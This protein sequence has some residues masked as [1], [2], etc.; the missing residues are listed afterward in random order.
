[1]KVQTFEAEINGTKYERLTEAVGAAQGGDTIRLINTNEAGDIDK[2]IAADIRITKKLTID[3]N[4]RDITSAGADW[5]FTL[6]GEDGKL[7]L[8]NSGDKSATLHGGICN[9]GTEEFLHIGEKIHL[10]DWIYHN[11]NTI[12]D[13]TH[14]KLYLYSD[15]NLNGGK[16]MPVTFGDRFQ[17]TGEEASL[18]MKLAEPAENLNAPNIEV[19]EIVIAHKAKADLA[20][21]VSLLGV[22]NPLVKVVFKPASDSAK[23]GD[24]VVQKELFSAVYLNG[25]SGDDAKDG[26]TQ[27]TAV[28]TFGK[29]KELAEALA[30]NHDRVVVYVTGTV[31]V[32][33]A[34]TWEFSS[35]GKIT[36][37]RE[38]AFSGNL[39]KV[40]SSGNLTLKNIVIDGN[41][42]NADAGKNSLI[43]VDGGKLTM[44]SGAVLQNNKLT[45]LEACPPSAGGA[46]YARENATVTLKGGTI[47]GN[48]A[49]W[50]GGIFALNAVI[51]VE[52][53]L[54]T[55][56]HAI[57][58]NK[59]EA[60]G[61]GIAT[62][63]Q[64]EINIS[65]G[66][67]SHNISQGYGGGISLG[68]PR[69]MNDGSYSKLKMT[70]GSFIENTAE[71]S[72]GGLFVQGGIGEGYARA[73][74]EA[75]IFRKIR[76]IMAPL[77]A[78]ES[79]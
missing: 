49:V 39:V 70:G 6:Y 60:A 8:I 53:G 46:V 51:H 67:I 40:G 77:A 18:I 44:L 62:W 30:D 5:I 56:N 32:D 36:M 55:R 35:S 57:K 1:M 59:D 27:A 65:G 3:L 66:T 75:G 74:V 28:K 26:L 58:A 72:G 34:E 21:K 2:V 13:G 43:L 10:A 42:H 38:P 50:G 63:Y 23:T 25:E 45:D 41:K 20:N 9:Y 37:Y 17:Y 11:Q 47:Q 76:R 33:A 24:L 22:T 61:A 29:A 54:I 78:A 14:E 7:S 4:G 79:M 71:N 48:T 64:S 52:D 15:K 69:V 73:K 31:G 19:Q 16:T 12:I 68:C